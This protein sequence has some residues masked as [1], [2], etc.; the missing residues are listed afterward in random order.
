MA[1]LGDAEA[2]SAMLTHVLFVV[3]VGTL[4]GSLQQ[5]IL[6]HLGLSLDRAPLVLQAQLLVYSLAFDAGGKLGL[7]FLLVGLQSHRLL[8]EL[9]DVDLAD[10]VLREH[11]V[12]VG[13]QSLIVLANLLIGQLHVFLLRLLSLALLLGL[14]ARLV[15]SMQ[16]ERSHITHPTRLDIVVCGQGSVQLQVEHLK[17][18]L[19]VVPLRLLSTLGH[20]QDARFE[21]LL[22]TQRQHPL[23]VAENK[24]KFI[25]D[26]IVDFSQLLLLLEVALNELHFG[27]VRDQ[28]LLLGRHLRRDL[29]LSALL[30]RGTRAGA[31]ITLID[32]A[33][34]VKMLILL[35]QLR[36]D[37]R[38]S[39]R[40]LH[41]Q[42]HLQLEQLLFVF[43]LVF[44]GALAV[45][46]ELH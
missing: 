43:A 36:Q 26:M 3:C 39:L 19:D 7:Q 42:L 14:E 32:A 21:R 31:L 20:G 23:L 10:G 46:L 6:V 28:L 41:R 33:A 11:F 4:D 22:K 30:S 2:A 18:R 17:I 15:E 38:G 8:V 45:F 1:Q 40:C 35:I 25:F 5:A 29:Q 12:V 9:L 37:L 16:P 13:N 34:K 24:L 44:G 27:L